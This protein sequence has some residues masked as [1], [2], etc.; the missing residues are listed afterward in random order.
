MRKFKITYKP[1]TK[2]E[3]PERKTYISISKPEGDLSQDAHS[4]VNIFCSTIGNLKKYDIIEIQ[5]L[6]SKGRNIGE[7]IRPINKESSII[8]I[9][10]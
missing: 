6:D 7:P 4:A 2:R 5:E 10:K 9:R 1:I 3:E 8:P